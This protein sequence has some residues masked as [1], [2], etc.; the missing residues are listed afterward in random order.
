MALSGEPDALLLDEPTTGL[1]VTTQA[2]ILE[3][4]R[5]IASTKGMAMIY[6]S[7]DLGAIARVCERVIVMYAGESVLEGETRKI[8]RN[9]SHPYARALLASIPK[10]SSDG[11]PAALDGRPPAPSGIRNQCAFSDRCGIAQSRCFSEHPKL[12]KLTNG[13]QCRCHFPELIEQIPISSLV[14]KPINIIGKSKP[15]LNLKTLSITYEKRGILDYI[16]G[17]KY[18]NPPTVDAIDLSVGI[19]ETLGL[20]GESGSGKSTIL[21]SIAGLKPL[22]SGDISLRD[23]SNLPVDVEKRNSEQLRRIQLIFQNPDESL[24]PVSYTH[25][26]AHET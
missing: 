17:N 7:H 2:H 14:P 21:K 16:F 1:D 22:K 13:E 15:A 8:L 11:F 24:N 9:P 6:V 26:R 18:R 23:G 20:V 3:L 12:Q 10:L 19:G 5:D 25:L 4:L